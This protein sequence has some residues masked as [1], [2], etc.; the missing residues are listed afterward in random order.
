GV[1]ITPII[2]MLKELQKQKYEKKVTIIYTNSYKEDIAYEKELSQD[3]GF[4]VNLKLVI[5]RELG[6]ERINLGTLRNNIKDLPNNDYYIVGGRAF[7]D[8]ME[9]LLNELNIG[10]SNI[11][12]DS[13]Y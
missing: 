3:F 1:G 7:G 8:S 4:D 9:C 2:P 12:A 11:Y 10:L 6:G 5:T 13:F